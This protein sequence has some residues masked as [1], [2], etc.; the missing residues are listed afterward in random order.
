MNIQIRK[1]IH[2][3]TVLFLAALMLTG[4]FCS[5]NILSAEAAQKEVYTAEIQGNYRSPASGEIEDGGGEESYALGQSMVESMVDPEGLLVSGGDGTLALYIRFHLMDQISDVKLSVQENG[6]DEWLPV[7]TVETGRT[8]E[9]AD[10]YIPVPEKDSLVRAE[11]YV[12]AMGRNVI[13]YVSAGELT[14]GNTTDIAEYDGAAPSVSAVSGAEGLT[15]GRTQENVMPET[16]TDRETEDDGREK[17]LLDDSVWMVLFGILFC[18]NLLSGLVLAGIA[19]LLF[20][21]FRRKKGKRAVEEEAEN[22]RYEEEDDDLYL[23]FDEEEEEIG[24]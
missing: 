7:E 17:I 3:K 14:E 2:R 8:E 4:W 6:S 1:K 19:V 18:A 24:Q 13:F 21:I 15:V 23:D 22:S 12:K 16:E 10:F 9:T 11:C 20:L 5:G